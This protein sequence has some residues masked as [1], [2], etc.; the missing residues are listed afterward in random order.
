MARKAT[1]DDALLG[2]DYDSALSG[3]AYDSLEF[4]EQPEGR[5][6][7]GNFLDIVRSSGAGASSLMGQG[8]DNS[9][10]DDGGDVIELSG[11]SGAKGG[12][13]GK[14]GGSDP[15]PEP[16]PEPTPSPSA[17]HTSGDTT[18]ADSAFNIRL[19]FSGE[20]FTQDL[21]DIFIAVADYFSSVITADLADVSYNGVDYDDITIDASIVP[22]D[23][24]GGILGQAGATLLRGGDSPDPYL[25]LEGMM[26]FD[27]ADVGDY[28]A[29]GTFDD[30]VFH[31]MMHVLGFTQGVWEYQ[32]LFASHIEDNGTKRPIDDTIDYRFTGADATI[33]YNEDYDTSGDPLAGSGVPLE[34]TG[35]SGTAGSH[36]DEN[37]FDGEI[38]TG[39]IDVSNQQQ[40]MTLAALDDMGYTV[41]DY[42]AD[43]YGS[44]YDY[45]A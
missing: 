20:G 5:P 30:I 19:N 22:I 18:N 4:V 32:E 15:E 10:R 42:S 40:D 27:S 44:E 3:L 17:S 34:T 9:R 35:G 12:V 24:S 37:T 29:A 45:L 25:P 13:P 38:M 14:P 39:Y 23:G 6:E 26:E 31:E 11:Y 1:F 2:L 33:Q 8:A 7:F 36:W 28:L 43:Y 41:A 21:M 16:E